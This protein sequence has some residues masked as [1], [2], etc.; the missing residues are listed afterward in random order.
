MVVKYYYQRSQTPRPPLTDAEIEAII[1]RAPKDEEIVYDEDCP[2]LTEEQYKQFRRI[3]P[4]TGHAPR[5]EA[6]GD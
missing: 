5:P 3:D 1:A 4:R 2:K 6:S